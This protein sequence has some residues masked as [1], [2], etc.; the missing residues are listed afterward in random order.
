MSTHNRRRRLNI[1]PL[2]LLIALTAIIATIARLIPKP[3]RDEERHLQSPAPVMAN[4]FSDNLGPTWDDDRII[5][6]I[7]GDEVRQ[8]RWGDVRPR[9]DP[10]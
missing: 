7:T 8:I 2:I 9:A 1:P 6:Q 5:F 4:Q 10:D 3:D